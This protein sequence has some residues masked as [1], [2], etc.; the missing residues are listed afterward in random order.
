MLYLHPHLLV[1]YIKCPILLP[2]LIILLILTKCGGFLIY[3]ILCFANLAAIF[4]LG[5]INRINGVCFKENILVAGECLQACYFPV[6]SQRGNVLGIKLP[7]FGFYIIYRASIEGEAQNG[8]N[9]KLLHAGL[10]AKL[11]LAEI[12][13]CNIERVLLWCW[14]SETLCELL[15]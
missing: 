9:D 1:S 14:L 12:D 4:L 15:T 2:A 3:Q 7:N 10:R 8:A 6:L 11:E 13:F 5:L